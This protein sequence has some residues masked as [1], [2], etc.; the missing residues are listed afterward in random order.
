[1]GENPVTA[2]VTSGVVVSLVCSGNKL[3]FLQ[4]AAPV[5]V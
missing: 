4:L 2:H 1:M 5:P 3:A